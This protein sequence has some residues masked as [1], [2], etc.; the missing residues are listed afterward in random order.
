MNGRLC[1]HCRDPG[2]VV[3]LLRVVPA[4]FLM[5]PVSILQPHS[6]STWF[7]PT[8]PKQPTIVSPQHGYVSCVKRN[9]DSTWLA[10]RKSCLTASLAHRAFPEGRGLWF[11]PLVRDQSTCGS[12]PYFKIQFLG[13]FKD[14]QP[15]KRTLHTATNT[16][17]ICTNS[18]LH[19]GARTPLSQAKSLRSLCEF[20]DLLFPSQWIKDMGCGQQ[21]FL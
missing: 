17:R 20:V 9:G 21:Y 1:S 15:P 8:E 7:R 13:M 10:L 6:G 11:V 18:Y 5:D 14:Q 3:S 19:H 2:T 16:S 12:L 4:C